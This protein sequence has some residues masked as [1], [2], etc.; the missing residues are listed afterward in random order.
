MS[1]VRCRC[2]TSL[3]PYEYDL[4]VACQESLRL[5]VK[6]GD[7]RMARCIPTFRIP[8]LTS[9]PEQRR[10]RHP[11]HKKF[12]K[13]LGPRTC[14]PCSTPTATVCSTTTTMISV[15]E[16]QYIL[17]LGHNLVVP[18][19]R[20]HGKDDKDVSNLFRC[21]ETQRCLLSM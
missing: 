16:K 3:V 11:G 1:T 9:I 15:A 19:E 4:M 12:G 14:A 2:G 21:I 17:S 10:T 13:T 5:E 6:N 7:P 18:S 20:Q 8:N